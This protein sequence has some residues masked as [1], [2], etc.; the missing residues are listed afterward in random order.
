MKSRRFGIESRRLLPPDVDPRGLEV[1]TTYQARRDTGTFSYA[2]HAVVLAVDPELGQVEILDYVIVEDGGVLINP[3]VV[4]GQ[5]YGGAA[6]GI[7][8][9]L[10]EEMRFSAEGQPLASTLAD[11]ILP[12]ATEVPAIRIE[13]MQTPS[14]YHRVRPEGHRRERR[15]RLGG[16]GRLCGER[17]LAS[18]GR[19]DQCIADFAAAHRQA[20][21][22]RAR[23]ARGMKAARFDYARPTSCIEAANLLRESAGRGKVVSGGQSLGAMMNLRLAQPE[24]LVDV[25]AIEALSGCAVAADAVILGANTT[26]AAIEDGRVSDPTGGLIRACGRRHRLPRR[27]QPRHPRRKPRPCGSGR[28][29]GEF[30]GAARGAVSPRRARWRAHG[31]RG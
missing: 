31:A 8:T 14:P 1:N 10:Y 6:Q 20:H 30:D 16:R 19:R 26:H 15:H 27:A 29:L 24:L 13:H 4:D 17:C 22:R 7:G 25:R 11:Y 28:R 21:Q 12:G 18:T 5:V 9:A 3:M 23:E 2:C